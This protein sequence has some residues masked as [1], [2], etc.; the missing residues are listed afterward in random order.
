M[1]IILILGQ[2]TLFAAKMGHKVVSV[3]PFYENIIRIHKS[4]Y[5]ANTYSN[6]I[7]ITNAISNKRNEIKLLEQSFNNIGGQSLVKNKDQNFEKNDNWFLLQLQASS[8]ICNIL[9]ENCLI[10]LVTFL[11]RY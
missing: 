3:E 9:K 7:L 8:L 1:K 2:Y 5:L 4:S 10:I 11:L 6:I